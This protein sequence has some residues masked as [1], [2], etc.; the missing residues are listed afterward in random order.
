MSGRVFELGLTT[1]TVPGFR[2]ALLVDVDV[3]PEPP[4]VDMAAFW[5]QNN[6]GVFREAAHSRCETYTSL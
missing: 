2:P 1:W 6:T 4:A 3:T 5:G